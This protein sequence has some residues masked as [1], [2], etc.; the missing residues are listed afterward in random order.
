MITFLLVMFYLWS[1]VGSIGNFI[2]GNTTTAIWCTI[3]A[4]VG[5]VVLFVKRK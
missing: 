2:L 3:G 1:I 5:T 4:V